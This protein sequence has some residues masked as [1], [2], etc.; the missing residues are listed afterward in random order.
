[1][2]EL[3]FAIDM[4]PSKVKDVSHDRASPMLEDVP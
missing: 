4:V 1:M 3:H 2:A